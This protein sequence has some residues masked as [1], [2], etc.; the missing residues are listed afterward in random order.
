MRHGCP[1]PRRYS[2][3]RG[4]PDPLRPRRR[5]KGRHHRHLYRDP[6]V[7]A[8]ARP[9]VGVL[10]QLERVQQGPARTARPAHRHPPEVLLPGTAKERLQGL[11]QVLADMPDA[12]PDAEPIRGRAVQYPVPVRTSPHRVSAP[13]V[14]VDDGATHRLRA[15]A[16]GDR[17]RALGCRV[18]APDREVRRPGP[19]L[20]AGQLPAMGRDCLRPWRQDSYPAGLFAALRQRAPAPARGLRLQPDAGE[21]RGGQGSPGLG[22]Q[23][24]TGVCPS[25]APRR[26]LRG[27][28]AS[29]RR[30]ARQGSGLGQG[31]IEDQARGDAR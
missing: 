18:W 28:G 27:R 11:L 20:P 17:Y 12:H 14:Q 19:V 2:Q 15:L 7:C 29:G 30:H 26:R 4:A 31:R 16:R 22:D 21:V 6:L 3:E 5:Q 8:L 25:R 9:D 10:G 24:A 13:R 1:A 23:E